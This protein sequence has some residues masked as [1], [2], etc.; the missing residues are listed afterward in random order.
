MGLGTGFRWYRT[1]SLRGS[2]LL[3][4]HHVVLAGA[5]L[6]QLDVEAERSGCVRMATED[7]KFIYRW[8]RPGTQVVVTR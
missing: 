4:D 7:V 2:L 3:R 5:G 8:A 1:R 6:D